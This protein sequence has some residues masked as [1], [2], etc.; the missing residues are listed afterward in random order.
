M[1]AL[2]FDESWPNRGETTECCVPVV[3]IDIVQANGGLV[4]LGLRRFR[5]L[6]RLLLD[7]VDAAIAPRVF[8]LVKVFDGGVSSELAFY[9]IDISFIDWALS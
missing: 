4:E 1:F 3:I 9:I 7:P 5:Y 8:A 6:R 2:D